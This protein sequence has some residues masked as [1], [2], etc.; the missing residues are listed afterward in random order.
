MHIHCYVDVLFLG[1]HILKS[2]VRHGHVGCC[3]GL[4]D[5][6]NLPIH[7]AA[8]FIHQ[9]L[10]FRALLGFPDLFV[11]IDALYCRDRCCKSPEFRIAHVV[12]DFRQ[13][14][15]VERDGNGASLQTRA[16]GTC[17]LWKMVLRQLGPENPRKKWPYTKNMNEISTRAS[18][19]RLHP[20]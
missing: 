18:D 20:S 19:N 13:A 3:Q 9:G 10:G 6:P 15:F 8:N 16:Q 7:L 14:L 1:F 11:Y 12:Q 2:S 17:R 5:D 4:T